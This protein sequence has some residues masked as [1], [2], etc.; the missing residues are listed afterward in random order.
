[1]VSLA[2]G[3]HGERRVLTYDHLVIALGS[4]SNFFE[5]PGVEERALTMKSLGDAFILRNQALGMLEMASLTDDALARRAMLT[6][7]IAG[8]GFAGVET[9]GAL[10]DFVREALTYYPGLRQEEVRV[11][12]VHPNSVLL[13]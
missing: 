7:V 4:E 13:S 5:L 3:V 11:V 6:F 12:L 1:Q 2:Y 8:G 10:N 9:V